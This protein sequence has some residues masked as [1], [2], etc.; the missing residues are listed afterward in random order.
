MNKRSY[1]LVVN[2]KSRK[3]SLAIDEFTKEF[4]ARKIKIKI[5]KVK[6]PAR[7]NFSL[8]KALDLNPDVIVLGG[9]DGTL[10]SGIEYLV[11]KNYKKSIGF[12]PLGTANYLVRNLEIPLTV[13]ES[14]DV[15]LKGKVLE[16]PIGIA[17]DK[18]F[19]LTFV[20]GL[21]QAVSENVSDGLKKK[22]GQVAYLLELF[23]QSTQHKPFQYRI[24]S[25]D[26]KKPV[27][28]VCHQLVVYNSDLNQQL[29]L[30]PDHQLTKHT[31]KVVISNTGT[32]KIKMFIGFFVHIATFGKKRPY[33]KVFE[34]SSLKITTDPE[35]PAD[36]DGETYG[37]SPFDITMLKRKIRVIAN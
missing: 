8:Q 12:L 24:E 34:A 3:A 9:G 32:S 2:L 33:M 27:T 20:V 17:N 30:V 10:I 35:L 19:A 22:I 21:T 16:I 25:P 7:I 29:K 5:L 13:P 1:V 37:K 11:K 14:V 6:N 36:F 15:L 23:K 4:K 31:L 18:Y 26:L 28:G